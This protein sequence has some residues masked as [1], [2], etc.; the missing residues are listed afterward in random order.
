[1]WCVT[2]FNTTKKEIQKA[3]F[4]RFEDCIGFLESRINILDFIGHFVK[5]SFV[6][7]TN[8]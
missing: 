2:Y 7:D 8:K 4:L 5:I 6:E 3:H 1:M